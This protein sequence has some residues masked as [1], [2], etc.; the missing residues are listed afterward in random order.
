MGKPALSQP[1]LITQVK[2][3]V[4]TDWTLLESADA[5]IKVIVKLIL[6]KHGD[7]PDLQEEAVKTVPAQAESLCAEFV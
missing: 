7:S 5:K 6:N 1:W 3:S 2:K 4:T